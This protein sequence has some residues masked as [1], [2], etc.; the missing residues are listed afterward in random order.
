MRI[1]RINL[2]MVS[3]S[4]MTRFFV[5]SIV[6]WS[7]LVFGMFYY[8]YLQTKEN[9]ISF[10]KNYALAQIERDVTYRQWATLH[11]GVYVEIK[12]HT[13]PNPYL[14][15]K[16][17]ELNVS[18]KN[19]T[20]VNPAYMMRQASE[21]IEEKNLTS[22]K[23]TSLNP[24]RPANAPDEWEKKVLTIFEKD[25]GSDFTEHIKDSDR[26]RV[27]KA[28]ITEEGCLKCHAHQGY[29]LGDIRGGISVSVNMTTFLD[30]EIKSISSLFFS[31]I[32][33]WVVG[34]L[35]AFVSYYIIKR[36]V[37]EIE[38]TNKFIEC[39]NGA[40]SSQIKQEVSSKDEASK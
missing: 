8:N 15:V 14:K 13:P 30:K 3:S 31:H 39:V 20:L 26:L 16:D 28:F 19:L 4:W 27:M 35:A 11:G 21:I 22:T 12:E 32:I 6:G 2:G 1:D 24:I 5:G 33:M 40:L 10:A 9:T 17:R 23:I 36:Y 34:L 29:K 38:E 18:G 25:G 37:N 7:V